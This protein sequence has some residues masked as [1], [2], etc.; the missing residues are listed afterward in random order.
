MSLRLEKQMDGMTAQ[1]PPLRGF[2]LPGASPASAAIDLARSM[3][4][5]AER[6]A[7]RL[8]EQAL[9]VNPEIVRYLNRLSDYLFILARYEDRNLP[10]EMVKQDDDK[11]Q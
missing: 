9:L 2:V 7:V 4:R 8:E 10:T 1:M 6:W 11:G 3:T 5:R